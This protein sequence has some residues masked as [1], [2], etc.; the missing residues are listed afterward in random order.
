M[1]YD[2]DRVVDRRGSGCF[3]YDALKM[4]Y[5]REDLLSLWVADMDFAVAPAI[6]E[7]LQKRLS[8]PVFGYNLQLPAYYDAIIRWVGSNYGFRIERDWILN[9]PGVM[10]AVNLAVMQLTDPC[11]GIVIQTPV[12][13]PFYKA[14]LDHGRKLLENPLVFANG[15]YEIDFDDL[16]RKLRQARMFILCSPHNPVGRLWS[17]E[18]LGRIGT[19]CRQ[20][21]VKVVSDEIHAD[22]VYDGKKALSIAS[23]EDFAD[24]SICCYSAAKSFNL[25]GLATAAIVVRDPELR[26]PLASMIEKLHL[27]TGNSFGIAALAAAYTEGADWL[28]ELMA[29]L[30]ANRDYLCQVVGEEIAPLRIVKPEATYLAWLDF[31]ELGLDDQGI[32]N[33]L[34]NRAGLALDPGPKF[35]TGGS[36]FQRL[37]FACPRS[38]L[39]EALERL[40]AAIKGV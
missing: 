1:K 13:R 33:L 34:I 6:V 23:L 17:V 11:D 19:L 2:F 14:V 9:S 21:G 24:I 25:A 38:I 8:H 30:Q 18:E 7:A 40:S 4:L 12:Y 20:Y 16:E 35:G 32:A 36:G 26:K 3:K 22:L 31:R 37:N 5:G 29:Y 27:Y 10:P 15:R 28:R 39:T